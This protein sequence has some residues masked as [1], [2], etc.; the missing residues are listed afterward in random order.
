VNTNRRFV[1]PSANSGY[2]ILQ[3]PCVVVKVDRSLR[4]RHLN[5]LSDVI[6][7]RVLK[8]FYRNSTAK[9]CVTW[10]SRCE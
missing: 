5:P 9:I 1:V 8:M 3:I 7:A 4:I 10:L 2:A 6:P